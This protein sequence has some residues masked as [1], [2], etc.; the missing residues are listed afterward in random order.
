MGDGGG[1]VDE[2]VQPSNLR[3]QGVA[4]GLK[5]RGSSAPQANP[6]GDEG[7]EGQEFPTVEVAGRDGNRPR[8]GM[9][10]SHRCFSG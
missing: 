3:L 1:W 7:A 10:Y 2:T 8:G 9:G 4:P 5:G 6:L